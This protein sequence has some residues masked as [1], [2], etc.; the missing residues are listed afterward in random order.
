M[1]LQF[2]DFIPVYP[3]QD[4]S[5]VQY[6]IGIKREFLEVSGSSYEPPPNKGQLYKH[7]KA[8]LRYMR[9]M[10]RML[11]IQSV[12]TGKTCALVAL[13]EYY[14]ENPGKIKHVYVLERGETTID[15]FKKQIAYNCTDGKYLTEKVID[16]TVDE[17]YRKGALTR[18]I[19]KFYSVMTY[20]ELANEVSKNG[21]SEEAINEKY[22]D[23]IFF[24]DEA[25]NLNE[26]RS[27]RSTKEE[28]AEEIDIDDSEKG[29]EKDK[30]YKIL[31]KLFH[32]VKRSKVI[33]ATATP[34]INEV[35]EIAPLMNLILPEDMQ[36]PLTWDY[37]KVTLDQLEPFFRGRIS[38]VR[39]LETGVDVEYQGHPINTL[40]RMEFPVSQQKVKFV[41]RICDSEG[42]GEDPPQPKLKL[43]T[44]DYESQDKIYPLVMS[45]FQ[46]EGY[47]KSVYEKK[48]FRLYERHA[49]SLVFPDHSYGGDFSK[50]RIRSGKYV[51]KVSGLDNTYILNKEF[52][53]NLTSWEDLEKYSIKYYFI[54]SKELEAAE[55]RQRGEIVGNGFC[56]TELLTGSG[57][58]ILGLLLEKFG[59]FEKYNESKSV[60]TTIRNEKIIDKNFK[61]KLRYGIL[62]STTTSSQRSSLLELFNSPEN[63]NGDYCQVIIGSPAA[64]DGINV[65]NVLRGYLASPGWHP[66]GTHQALSRFIRSTSHVEIIK[67]IKNRMIEKGEDPSMSKIEV[68]VWKLAAVVDET[69]VTEPKI[70]D[71]KKVNFQDDT[72]GSVDIDMYSLSESKDISI[73]R[74]IR[75]MKQCAFDCSIHYNRNVRSADVSGSGVCDYD[76][77]NYTCYSSMLTTDIKP[78][79]I[80][81][82]TFDILY[83]QDIVNECRQDI[84]K[85][86]SQLGYININNLY[87]LPEMSFYKIKFINMAIDQ[88]MKDKLTIRDKFGFPVYINTNGFTIFTQ[89]KLPFASDNK[90]ITTFGDLNIY[91]DTMVGIQH[92]SFDEIISQLSV[93]DDTILESIRSM[94]NIS[95]TNYSIFSEKFDLLSKGKRTK[96]IE[97]CIIGKEGSDLTK[98]ILEKYKNFIYIKHEPYTDIYN[99]KTYLDTSNTRR[100][101]SRKESKKQ[102]VNIEMF[103]ENEDGEEVCLH[104]FSGINIGSTSFRVNSQFF[105]SSDDIYIYKRSENVGWRPVKDY[106]W[107]AYSNLILKDNKSRLDK[108]ASKYKTFGTILSDKKFRIVDSESF[109]MEGIDKRVMTMG[110][111]CKNYKDKIDIIDILL[112]SNYIIPEIDSI[113]TTFNTRK[114]FEQF[115]VNDANIVKSA[116][117]LKDYSLKDLEYITKWVMSRNSTTNICAYVK[118]MMMSQEDRLFVA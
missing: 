41:S 59:N 32:R 75:M 81:D 79:E 4:D 42:R 107:Q 80:D 68:K 60:F 90:D 91:K 11:N 76:V 16:P 117:R 101:R 20:G 57:A 84:V 14:N 10:D 71:L 72:T 66:S 73:K 18:E 113:S 83:S 28:N 102:K 67:V 40:F 95:T 89:N 93:N 52:L 88:I 25:H 64:R 48:S 34:M 39:A 61:P 3:R 115:L 12:G 1:S 85:I 77:C 98:A 96:I 82:S 53:N 27:L 31:W 23:C 99:I 114:E 47:E 35:E 100:G 70:I 43:E 33:L 24:V 56:F 38:Y 69:D 29:K 62:T 6:K 112:E 5:N 94:E 54:I 109:R 110:T 111:E 17:R 19:G 36:M 30:Y 55:K 46:A 65:F 92:Q 49:A 13:G 105:N 51:N 63:V 7:Q 108:Y 2:E 15:E 58:I 86:V 97:D 104:T 9:Q 118:E 45:D 103:G 106:E 78:E 74:I 116:S 26:D 44:K 50:T 37:N 21:L 22:S 87:T 8:F